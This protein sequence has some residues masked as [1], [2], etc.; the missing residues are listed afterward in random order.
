MVFV[1]IYFP[2][3]ATITAI[4]RETESWKYGAFSMLYNTAVAW[5]LSFVTYRVALLFF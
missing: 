2:C 3:I 5:L 4:V 1:L